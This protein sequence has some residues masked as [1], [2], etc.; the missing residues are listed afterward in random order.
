M[1]DKDAR[2]N[3]T[4][5]L[6]VSVLLELDRAA[7]EMHKKKNEIVIEALAT[8]LREYKQERLYK[9]YKNSL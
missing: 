8:W 1:N 3:F 6:P 7:Q 9:S 2:I 4:T 5:T